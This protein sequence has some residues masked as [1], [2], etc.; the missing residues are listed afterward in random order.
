MRCESIDLP[1]YNKAGKPGY[2]GQRALLA[3]TTTVHPEAQM[4][5]NSKP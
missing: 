2:D 4:V 3:T 5:P 1:H